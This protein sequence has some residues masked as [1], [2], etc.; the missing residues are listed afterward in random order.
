M[1]AQRE[2][3]DHPASGA[4]GAA[5]QVTM[6]L[7]DSKAFL[8]AVTIIPDP[9]LPFTTSVVLQAVRGSLLQLHALRPAA[10]AKYIVAENRLNQISGSLNLPGEGSPR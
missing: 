2:A 1:L 5:S 4:G 10:A 8:K 6:N 7:S 9:F 3:A